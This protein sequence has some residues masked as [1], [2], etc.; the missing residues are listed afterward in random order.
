[1]QERAASLAPSDGRVPWATT[2][3]RAYK[4]FLAGKPGAAM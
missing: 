4:V 2:N 3:T 1:M